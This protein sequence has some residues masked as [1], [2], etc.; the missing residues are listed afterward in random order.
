LR[1]SRTL[2]GRVRAILSADHIN[3]RQ[4]MTAF[5]IRING[6]KVCTV[7]ID[8]PGV[9]SSIVSW[10][11]GAPREKGPGTPERIDIRIGGLNSRTETHYTWLTR[12]LRV[13]D[14]VK[15]NVVTKTKVDRAAT[16]RSSAKVKALVAKFRSIPSK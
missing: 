13:G 3:V 5:E 2:R 1:Q 11:Q 4:T 7:G 9:V 6:K 14:E 16:R 10:M 15:I 8:E 12:G